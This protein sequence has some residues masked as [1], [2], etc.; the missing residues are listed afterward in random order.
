MAVSALFAKATKKGRFKSKKPSWREGF[1]KRFGSF[2]L[3]RAN[4]RS[5]IGEEEL[6]FRVR[7]GIGCALFSVTAKIHRSL[8][9]PYFY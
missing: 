4:M 9:E 1:L 7:N 8:V 6:N 3:S 2:L 5:I